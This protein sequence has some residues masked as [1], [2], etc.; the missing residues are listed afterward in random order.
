MNV[1]LQQLALC[2]VT[3]AVF[4]NLKFLKFYEIQFKKLKLNLQTKLTVRTTSCR[5]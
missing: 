3:P 2:D 1:Y 4:L 5:T